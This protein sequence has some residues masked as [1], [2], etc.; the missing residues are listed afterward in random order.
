M[1]SPNDNHALLP[2]QMEIPQ[3]GLG[4]IL[5]MFA[6][7]AA[8]NPLVKITGA[9]VAFPEVNLVGK[10][11]F[12]LVNFMVGLAFNVLGEEVNYR[13][14]LLPRMRRGSGNGNGLRMECCSPRNTSVSAGFFLGSWWEDRD[15]RS[16]RDRW[17]ACRWQWSFTGSGTS[18]SK[19]CS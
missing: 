4:R 14:C 9:A 7:P 8:R 19:Q 15:S 6:G 18:I 13:V 17:A 11:F 5:L 1:V 3:D 16:P 10:Y 12:V 2:D